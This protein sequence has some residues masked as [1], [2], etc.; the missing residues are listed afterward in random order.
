MAGSESGAGRSPRVGGKPEDPGR[1][2]G[3]PVI[4]LR[5]SPASRFVTPIVVLSASPASAPSRCR[6]SI[7]RTCSVEI[8]AARPEFPHDREDE[9]WR[10]DGEPP[11]QVYLA[12]MS[13]GDTLREHGLPGPVSLGP[14]SSPCAARS[15]HEV[16]MRAALEEA[17]RAAA[18]GEV[19]VGA[20]VVVEGEVIGRGHNGPIAASDPTAHAEVAALRAAARR[21][22]NYR[23]TGAT[24]YVTVEPC[25]MC[26]GAALNARVA[27]VV[28]GATD[29]KAG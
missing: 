23:L 1:F 5:S 15:A 19:P 12:T 8:A 27:E 6:P 24:L 3:S 18:V 28:F 17:R 21:V 9:R 2:V 14:P 16:C 20:V 22:R 26:A 13:L 25:V 29:E 11:A 10:Q 4:P 7:G